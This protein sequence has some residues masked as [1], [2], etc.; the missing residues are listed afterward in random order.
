MP[1]ACIC[2]SAAS[3]AT[4]RSMDV[5]MWLVVVLITPS[6]PAIFTA[7]RFSRTMQKTGTPSM[8]APSNRKA[9]PA[10]V[11]ASRSVSYANAT[12]PL[13]AVT[14]WQPL[15]NGGADM[16]NRWFAVDHVERRYLDHD[17]EVRLGLG[18]VADCRERVR[19]RGLRRP[20]THGVWQWPRC[21]SSGRG[22]VQGARAARRAS[23]RSVWRRCRSRS[24][25]CERAS[26]ESVPY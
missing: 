23:A 15:S 5:R 12:G 24:A 1:S 26:R 13:F 8:T 19:T 11:A 16:R 21:R 3:N 10:L 20:C 7:G 2:A 9:T 17:P 14:T 22:R 6:N 18:N 4:P 25:L